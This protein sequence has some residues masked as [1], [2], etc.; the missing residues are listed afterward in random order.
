[1]IA[2][3]NVTAAATQMACDWDRDANVARAEKLMR[4]AARRG[5]N[6]VLPQELFETPYFCK[7]HDPRHFELAGP[8]DGHPTVEHFRSLARE[9]G[10]VLPVSVFERA[11]QSFFNSV[12]VVDA[13]GRVLG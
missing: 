11:G 13:D 6:I 3:R 2:M 9:L 7:D 12:V 8:L 1:M 5:A 10:V 4:E